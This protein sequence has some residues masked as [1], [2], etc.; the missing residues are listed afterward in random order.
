MS[1]N[2]IT[3]ES[4][5]AKM[6][7]SKVAIRRRQ[8]LP[9][10]PPDITEAEIAEVVDAIRSGWITTGPRTKRFEAEFAAYVGADGA[11]ALNS[12]TAGLHLALATLGVGPGDEVISTPMTFASSINVIEHVGATPVLADIDPETLNLDPAKVA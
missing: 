8:F 9:F 2:Q 10:S 6:N 7:P 1:S 5:W 11:L 12:C 4:E 3:R